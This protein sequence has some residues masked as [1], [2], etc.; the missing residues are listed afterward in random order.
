[1]NDA[2][3]MNQRTIQNPVS[4]NG[5][6]L[7]TGAHVTLTMRPALAGEGLCF[8]RTDL[9]VRPVVRVCPA[10]IVMDE[11]VTRCTVLEEA[12]V[13]VCTVEHILAAVSGL[14]ID[15]LA[16]EINGEEIPGLDGSSRGFVEALNKAGI[17]EQDAPKEFIEIAEPITK[18]T[19]MDREVMTPAPMKSPA[20]ATTKPMSVPS[21][22]PHK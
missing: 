14:G 4:L 12:G 22:T 3:G 6:G 1:M 8:I 11:H 5:I 13:R 16:I 2:A 20:P 21:P 19:P 10:A 15:N 17:V 18:E 9:P 7:H